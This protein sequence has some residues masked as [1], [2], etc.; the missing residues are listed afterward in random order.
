[1]NAATERL[2]RAGLRVT[3]ARRG[4]L[5]V[6]ADAAGEPGHLN[7]IEVH[8]RM[9]TADLAVDLSTVHRV[10]VLQPHLPELEFR[11][12]IGVIDA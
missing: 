4:V 6:L 10:L 9:R 1:M 7:A 5:H 2:R 3:M 12:V 11:Q 8:R